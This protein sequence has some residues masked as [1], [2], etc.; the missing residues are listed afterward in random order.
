MSRSALSR[1]EGAKKMR[2]KEAED[3]FL[4]AVEGGR[5]NPSKT[6]PLWGPDDSFHFNP[7]LLEKI[8]NH[9]Y[10][11]K[12]CREITDWN[13]LVDE[14]YYSAQ[15]LEPFAMGGQPSNA[16]CL[17]LRL[18]TL[19]C[20]EKQMKLLLDHVDSPYIR[21]IGFLY[22]R[23]AGEPTSIWKWIEPYLNDDEPITLTATS[24]K[25]KGNQKSN[26][27][28]TIGSLVRKL[29]SERDFYG[30]MLPRLPIQ[31]E[32]DLQ[33]KLLFAEKIQERAQKHLANYKTMAHFKKLGSRVMALYGDDENPI[34]WYEGVVDQVL[35]QEQGRDLKVPKFVVTFPEYGNTETVTLGEME[36]MGAKLDSVKQKPASDDR[37]YGRSDRNRG[38]YDRGRGYDRGSDRGYDRGYNRR[39]NDRRGYNSNGGYNDDRGRRGNDSRRGYDDRDHRDRGRDNGPRRGYDDRDYRRDNGSRR[40]YG[41]SGHS[42][43]S[44]ALPSSD[45]LYEEV[46]RRERETAQSSRPSSNK[47]NDYH[48]NNRHDSAPSRDSSHRQ[49][50]YRS[51]KR[52]SPPPSQPKAAPAEK[53][54]SAEEMA[55]QQEKRRKLMARY[56]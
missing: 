44:K 54:R 6:L 55:A 14:I 52:P 28:D 42:Q 41:D 12:C 40:G 21:G 3:L 51:E 10:F 50:S 48:R 18:L 47:R 7:V 13:K 33:V 39:D 5:N 24:N 8:I 25:Q 11:H 56:G 35:L 16:F 43:S 49:D 22:L 23:F 27:S 45:D 53:K 26:K 30:T 37:G 31:V 2:E 32:R 17:L 19:R 15:D 38:G 9:R 34:T 1:Q 20:S 46:R 4:M 36:I 29:W